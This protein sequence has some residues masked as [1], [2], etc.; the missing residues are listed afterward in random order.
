MRDTMNQL[1][2][3]MSGMTADT[4]WIRAGLDAQAGDIADIK[5]ALLDHS[6]SFDRHK[7]T[8]GANGNLSKAL[9]VIAALVGL[10]AAALGF[11][12]L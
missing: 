9:G 2:Q 1:G 8:A 6:R 7:A 5:R 12:V 4:K 10:L 3:T 11:G